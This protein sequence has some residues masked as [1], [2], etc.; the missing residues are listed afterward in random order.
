MPD[1]G[2]DDIVTS[3]GTNL[4]GDRFW[5]AGDTLSDVSGKWLDCSHRRFFI[6]LLFLNLRYGDDGDRALAASV[7]VK[8]HGASVKIA[9]TWRIDE[10]L[11]YLF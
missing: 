11:R 5:R 7:F 4:S 10:A 9:L 2:K 1:W 8:P 6:V 3:V